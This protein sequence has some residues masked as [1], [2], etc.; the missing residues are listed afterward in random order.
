MNHWYYRVFRDFSLIAEVDNI[1]FTFVDTGVAHG[2]T[3]W[4][5]VSAVNYFFHESIQTTGIAIEMPSP[6]P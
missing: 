4:H 2:A 1:H 6:L 5:S 3:Y